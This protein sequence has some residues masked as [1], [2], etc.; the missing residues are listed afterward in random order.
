M[1]QSQDHIN[2]SYSIMH[3]VL[4]WDLGT[5]ANSKW[6][7]VLKMGVGVLKNGEL[8]TLGY[9][10]MGAG[11]PEPGSHKLYLLN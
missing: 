6:V 10:K 1:P 9:S 11:V 4:T 5:L 3:T 7:G 2:Y 8:G